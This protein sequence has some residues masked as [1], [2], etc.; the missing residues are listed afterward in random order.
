MIRAV[1]FSR[2]GRYDGFRI[3]GHAGCGASGHDIACASVSSAVELAANTITDVIGAGA[4]VEIQ[5]K[6]AVVTLRLEQTGGAESDAAEAVIR[7]L[8]LHLKLLA[9]Q[10][11][12]HIRVEDLEVL[13]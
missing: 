8:R 13:S 1:F 5:K 6:S 9:N 11:H 12:G 2:R 4:S 7:G 10:F 3:G